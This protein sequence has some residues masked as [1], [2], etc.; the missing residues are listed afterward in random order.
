MKL[1]QARI[2]LENWRRRSS[3]LGQQLNGDAVACQR[4]HP[5]QLSITHK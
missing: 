4:I 1:V 5:A 3:G 2:T